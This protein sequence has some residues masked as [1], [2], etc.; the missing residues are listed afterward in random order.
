MH[1]CFFSLSHRLCVAVVLMSWGHEKCKGRQVAQNAPFS[2]FITGSGEKHDLSLQAR[3]CKVA[4]L[5]LISHFPPEHRC[6]CLHAK[7]LVILLTWRKCLK[8]KSHGPWR[9]HWVSIITG[10]LSTGHL[11][12]SVFMVNQEWRRHSPPDLTWL[13][14]LWQAKAS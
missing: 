1:C 7:L 14:W 4:P 5:L 10:L 2:C 8:D 13:S 12:Y 11:C 9:A 6:C 3:R